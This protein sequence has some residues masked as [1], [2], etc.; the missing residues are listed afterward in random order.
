[1]SITE[2]RCHRLTAP[3]HTPFVTALRRT[4]HLETTVVEVV[5]DDGLSGY[6][7]APQVWRVTGESLAGAE[8]CLSGPLADV[9]RGRSVDDLPDLSRLLADA[10]VGNF[11][12]KAAMDVAL[13]DLASRR[14]GVSLT[15]FL[16]GSTGAQRVPT[17]VT[18]SAGEPDELSATATKRTAEGFT[19]LKLKVGT[20]AARDVARVHA[21]RQAAPEA[22]IRVDA[23]QGWTPDQAIA[24]IRAMED[25]GLDVEFVEQP[26]ERHDVRGLAAVTAA[27]DTPVMADES[28][29]GLRDLAA[30]I[31]QRAADLVNV[32]LAK[33]GGLGVARELLERTRAAG[34]GTIVGS[35]MEGPIGVGAAAALVAA[36]GTSHVSD[37]DAA[38]WASASPVVG[39][40][41]Y[42]AG[43]IVLPGT[44]GL[45]IDG[46][47]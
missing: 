34:M 32:K 29:F 11:G 21:V 14:A 22:R 24:V 1:M 10:V 39:G 47:R 31:D 25:A 20:D 28:V 7:E 13:H 18:V 36:V 37:L 8:A 23:N 43:V 4:E 27:V 19:V 2:I 9:V 44:G 41:T 26:V 40:A 6:G 45:G 42:D 17:D 12:A 46:L 30:V 33:C 5:D 15:A 35:M 38:W 3:L 16:G